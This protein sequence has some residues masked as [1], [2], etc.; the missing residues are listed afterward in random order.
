M[1]TRT[2]HC[3][4]ALWM[5]STMSGCVLFQ[6]ADLAPA[7]PQLDGTWTGHIES[8]DVLDRNG[9]AVQVAALRVES[10]PERY[11]SSSDSGRRPP[12][13]TYI[14][15]HLVFTDG[16]LPILVD[17]KGFAMVPL[18]DLLGRRVRLSGTMS[19]GPTNAPGKHLYIHRR[20]RPEGELA[21]NEEHILT[22]TGTIWPI[23]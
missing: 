11:S 8:L 12:F 14:A 3:I 5:A 15:Q 7:S 17:G 23:D 22:V 18:T 6:I 9:E 19:A 2:L 21:L 10:G 20:H 4:L 1:R 16:D 13:K